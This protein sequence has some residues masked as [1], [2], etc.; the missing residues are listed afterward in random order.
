MDNK[1]RWPNTPNTLTD[2]LSQMGHLAQSSEITTDPCS[3]WSQKQT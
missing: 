2:N 1:F 3:H